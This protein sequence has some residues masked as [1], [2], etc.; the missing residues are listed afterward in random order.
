ME[1][2]I[3]TINQVSNILG[4]SNAALRK[5]EKDYDLLIPRNELNHRYYTEKEI[6]VFEQIL[7]LKEKGA[8]IHV[9]K[10]LL[11][12]SENL[13]E[14]KEQA[15]ELVTLDKITGAEL[16]DLMVKQIADIMYEREKELEKKYEDKINTA[17]DEIREEIIKEFKK[18]EEQRTGENEKLLGAIE[19]IRN[20]EKKSFWG[21][22]LRK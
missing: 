12:R 18:Q 10:S 20:K 11:S 17:K 9:I 1:E 2:K 16:K 6:Q 14:Q 3:Y 15:L 13:E 5:Y 8:N 19:K 7:G 22:L 21:R 4:V